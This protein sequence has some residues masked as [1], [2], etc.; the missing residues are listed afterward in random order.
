MFHTRPTESKSLEAGTSK[1]TLLSSSLT[2]ILCHAILEKQCHRIIL[3]LLMWITFLV[4]VIPWDISWYPL[5][6]LTCFLPQE[7]ELLFW[8]SRTDLDLLNFFL[9]D[10]IQSSKFLW[11]P[12]KWPLHTL[13]NWTGE[14]LLTLNCILQ[15]NDNISQKEKDYYINKR[16]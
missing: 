13:P 8:L 3:F 7:I 6:W 1:D 11:S 4:F 14:H 16:A 15:H 5:S 10:A 12:E 2:I 9:S